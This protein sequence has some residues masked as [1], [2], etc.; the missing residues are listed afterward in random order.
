MLQWKLESSYTALPEYPYSYLSTDTAPSPQW[1]AFNASLEEALGMGS[2]LG[3]EVLAI[4]P[5]AKPPPGTRAFAQAYVGHQFGQFSRLGDGRVAVLS[6]LVEPR[7][8]R[9]GCRRARRLA[10]LFSACG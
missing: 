10:A 2:A 8:K 7:G 3:R 1:A 5:G 4:L 9:F 6:E